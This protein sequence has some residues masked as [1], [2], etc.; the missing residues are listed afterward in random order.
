MQERKGSNSYKYKYDVISVSFNICHEL[1][2]VMRAQGYWLAFVNA[3][4]VADIVHTSPTGWW[5]CGIMLFVGKV[6]KGTNAIIQ[7]VSPVVDGKL[8]HAGLCVFWVII[9][10]EYVE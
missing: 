2:R 7:Q 1:P 5:K 6:G 4:I 8:L 3:W 10:L 9:Q